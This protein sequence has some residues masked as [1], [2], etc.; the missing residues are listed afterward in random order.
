[1]LVKGLQIIHRYLLQERRVAQAPARRSSV[2]RGGDNA[3]AHR[4]SVV[5]VVASYPL[6]RHYGDNVSLRRRY[7]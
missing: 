1:M 3:P 7:D 2:G 6:R 5:D 4:S